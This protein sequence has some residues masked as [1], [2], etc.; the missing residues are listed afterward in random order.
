VGATFSIDAIGDVF[1]ATTN[2]EFV[3]CFIAL[4]AGNKIKLAAD[5]N[6]TLIDTEIR[7]CTTRHNGIDAT[8]GE[9]WMPA[10]R[11]SRRK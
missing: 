1:N 3:N 11:D 2:I 6:I 5:K 10:A 4:S 7:N 9:N 8:A